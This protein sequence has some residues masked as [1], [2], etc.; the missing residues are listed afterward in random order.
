MGATLGAFNTKTRAEAHIAKR[1]KQAANCTQHGTRV[2]AQG[3]PRKS[4]TDGPHQWRTVSEIGRTTNASRR[5]GNH[6]TVSNTGSDRVFGAIG[7]GAA[8]KHLC[9]LLSA[10]TA[11][12]VASAAAPLLHFDQ[13]IATLQRTHH[14]ANSDQFII[15]QE[16]P[17]LIRCR[18]EQ[19]PELGGNRLTCT[20]DTRTHR[21][22][23]A[24]HDIGNLLVGKPLEFA[25]D[26][27]RS[28]FLGK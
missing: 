6:D 19:G 18:V 28:Q 23:R 17:T 14:T 22:D 20:K 24:M 8:T 16:L 25:Q 11:L 1:G 2:A 10:A 21:A 4:T 12:L 27:R 9:Q 15:H 13:R 26:D 3:H 7:F 5:R